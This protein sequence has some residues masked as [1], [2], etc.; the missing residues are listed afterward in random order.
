MILYLDHCMIWLR[1]LII[2]SNTLIFCL[3]RTSFEYKSPSS[4]STKT[5]M[6]CEQ[7]NKSFVSKIGYTKHMNAH[8]GIYRYKCETCNKGFACSNNY[9]EHLSGHTGIC[10]FQCSACRQSFRYY[11]Q[12]NTHK[13]RQC[14]AGSST[15]THKS[16]QCNAGSSTHT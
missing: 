3:Q 15:H 6:Y 12:L 11:H 13:S 7:C 1:N 8:K 16:R 9:K 4:S 5:T 2:F 10:Y 14:N